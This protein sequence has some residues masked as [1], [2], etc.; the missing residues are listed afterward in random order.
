[1][2][3]ALSIREMQIKTIL[4]WDF[5]PITLTKIQKLLVI[6]IDEAVGKQ[7]FS[8]TAGEGRVPIAAAPMTVYLV[9]ATKI[10]NAYCPLT[11]NSFL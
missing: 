10:V 7:G 6:S 8:Y 3:I 11:H 4:R 1:M 2:L 5:S 9:I